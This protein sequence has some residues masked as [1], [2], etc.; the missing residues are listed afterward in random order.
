M[1]PLK[2]T[3]E[4]AKTEQIQEVLNLFREISAQLKKKGL[5]QWSYW[6]DPPE[7]KIQWVREGFEKGEFHFVLNEKREWVG[8]FRLL[9]TD[10]LYWDEKGLEK[11][12]RY[13]HS[14]VVK[15]EKSG[16]GIGAQVLNELASRLKRER[17]HKLRL[18]CDSSNA[19]L[20]SYYE[21]QGFDKIGEKKTPFSVN[22]LY[23][24]NLVSWSYERT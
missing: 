24:K 22:N 8:M 16:E 17:V 15:P 9:E 11:Q 14:L 2:L 4:P 6:A 1:I 18:D 5:T 10:T 7:E 21:G 20:C 19:R 3:F 23:E 12:V 13:I